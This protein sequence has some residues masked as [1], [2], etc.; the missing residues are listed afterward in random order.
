MLTNAKNFAQATL[1]LPNKKVRPDVV[2]RRIEN[3]ISG[4]DR[5]QGNTIEAL[6]APAI[7]QTN[8]LDTG[9]IAARFAQNGLDANALLEG[10]AQDQ[11]R[12]QSSTGTSD[13]GGDIANQIA[14]GSSNSIGD[15]I[16]GLNGQEQG[17]STNQS[18][19]QPQGQSA[20]Q[21][22]VPGNSQ[23]TGSDINS[24]NIAGDIA[25]QL[26][27]QPGSNDANVEDVAGDL[28]NQLAPNGQG[29][30]SPQGQADAQQNGGSG[31][32]I[33]VVS[34]IITEANGQMMATA[35][36]EA[37]SNEPTEASSPAPQAAATKASQAAPKAP[38][39]ASSASQS[40]I[41]VFPPG[42][43]PLPAVT[44]IPWTNPP[45]QMAEMSAGMESGTSATD[46]AMPVETSA[47]ATSAEVCNAINYH[48]QG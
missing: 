26:A 13:V 2:G 18:A 30:L 1:D 3:L 20:S 31:Q 4:T 38:L 41:T 43:S 37:A 22:M 19:L 48:S 39:E 12:G 8:T 5:S 35:L 10:L 7:E 17:A 16:T 6:S 24:S 21:G 11:S 34:T 9:N 29:Q 33:E 42:M 15:I 23:S 44:P 28:A 36:V 25:N 27:P 32:I 40:V 46:A 14:G 45:S 47:A